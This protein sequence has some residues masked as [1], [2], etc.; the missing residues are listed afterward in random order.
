MG[1]KFLKTL[2]DVLNILGRNKAASFENVDFVS[3]SEEGI[4][5]P[6]GDVLPLLLKHKSGLQ[7]EFVD[8]SLLG[9]LIDRLNASHSIVRLNHVGFCY[10]VE[11]QDAEKERFIKL[12][13][14]SKYHLYEE[15]SNDEGV[16]LFIGNAEDWEKPMVEMIPVEETSDKWVDYWLPHIQIDIDTT[17]TEKEIVKYVKSTFGKSINPFSIAIDGTVYIVRNRLGTIDGVNITLDLATNS[18]NV[19]YA[20][21]NI[22]RKI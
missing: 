1:S 12:I 11:S 6:V 5:T 21:Q 14:D 15:Q 8:I 2:G 22:L 7:D 4:I 16:W 10:K 3:L 13:N 20:R 19:K 17:L 9:E 18:R